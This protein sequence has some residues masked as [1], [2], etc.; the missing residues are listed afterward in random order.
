MHPYEMVFQS[1]LARRKSAD[2]GQIVVKASSIPWQQSR[3]GRS[4]YFIHHMANPDTALR[5]WIVFEKEILGSEEACHTHQGGIV[6]YVTRGRGHSVV[7]GERH[8]W[9]TGD[10]LI[11]PVQPG[12]CE[13]QHF[14]DSE[15]EEAPRWL[16]FVYLPIPH[17]LGSMMTQVTEAKGW[18]DLPAVVWD[19]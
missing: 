6:I 16:A 5:D 2:E 19:K 10:I 18:K 11:L 17:A 15:G 3:Q 14:S 13:H 7:D 1:F 8:D 9:K 12:G 4:K